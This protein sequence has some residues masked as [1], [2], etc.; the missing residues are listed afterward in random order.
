V[1]R[2]VE[3]LPDG[4]TG[5]LAGLRDTYVARALALLHRDIARTWSVDELGRDV[6]PLSRYRLIAQHGEHVLERRD[7]GLGN[8]GM[9]LAGN[10]LLPP[11]SLG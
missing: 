11:A 10:P 4:Q 6:A 7:A 8:R 5:W 2:Y 9:E 1:R 3:N